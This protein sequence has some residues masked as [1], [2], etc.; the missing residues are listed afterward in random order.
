[1]SKDIN[2]SMVDSFMAIFGMKRIASV[3]D[4]VITP[5]EFERCGI[6]GDSDCDNPRECETGD[7]V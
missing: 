6:C 4:N 1:M 5:V 7:G 3:S 2:L